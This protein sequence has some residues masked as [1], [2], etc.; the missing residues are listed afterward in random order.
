MWESSNYPRNTL[1]SGFLEVNKRIST[2]M[3]VKQTIWTSKNWNKKLF[4]KSSS[5]TRTEIGREYLKKNRRHQ[6]I[7]AHIETSWYLYRQY[8]I[9]RHP[10]VASKKWWISRLTDYRITFTWKVFKRFPKISD[11]CRGW[12]SIEWRIIENCL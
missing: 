9:I 2:K 10:S 6:K 12:R 7:Y 3:D 8:S 5:K 1:Y 4:W 11:G